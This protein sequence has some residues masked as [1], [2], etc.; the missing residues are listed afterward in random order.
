MTLLLLNGTP[1]SRRMQT[2][3]GDVVTLWLPADDDAV[4]VSIKD[5]EH[6]T[7]STATLEL[8]EALALAGEL[9]EAA[10]R[11]RCRA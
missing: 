10:S 3:L 1:P 4:H 11:R 5:A 9:T 8:D 6:H 2:E 7:T